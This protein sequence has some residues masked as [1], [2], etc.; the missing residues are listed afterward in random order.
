MKISVIIVN[1]NTKKLLSDCI[2]SVYKDMPWAEV[3]VVDNGSTDGSQKNIKKNFR[4]VILI[5]N[6]KNLG[7][8]AANNVG[9]K[10][11]SGDILFFLNSDT[12][13]PK[14]SLQKLID[15]FVY[16]PKAGVVGPKVVLPDGDLQPY[17]FGSDISLITILKEKLYRLI[18]KKQTPTNVKRVDWVTG[19]ALLARKSVFK[20]I[21]GFDENFF[22]YFEDN[23]LCL[24]CRQFGYKVYIY[25]HIS[26]VHLGGKS[27]AADE[28]R[29]KL[30][31]KSQDYFFKKHYG[32]LGTVTLKILRAPYVSLRRKVSTDENNHSK[33]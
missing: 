26:I 17:S 14:G 24:R 31:F 3:I 5:E 4:K 33:K 20:V 30:Y 2:R 7:F 25:P 1:L 22:M 16:Y 18:G 28:K 19:A 6:E 9:A 15:F 11:A 29:A 13:V 8:G 10:K 32:E 12:I 27:I 21:G 23:D